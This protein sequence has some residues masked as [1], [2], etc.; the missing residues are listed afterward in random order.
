MHER[1]VLVAVA[2]IAILTAWSL[3]L[4]S[5]VRGRSSLIRWRNQV[6]E[7]DGRPPA[8]RDYAS[9]LADL[10]LLLGKGSDPDA[11]LEDLRFS[12]RRHCLRFLMWGMIFLGLIAITAI[13]A[14]IF[15]Q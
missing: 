7:R 5:I 6:R 9:N 2:G 15:P 1:N 11:G 10:R 13:V 4:Y 3:S 12:A 14:T 8:T